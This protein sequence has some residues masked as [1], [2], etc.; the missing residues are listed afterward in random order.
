MAPDRP[1]CTFVVA[2]GTADRMRG[3]S[4]ATEAGGRKMRRR[5]AP[6][7]A[8]TAAGDE[9]DVYDRRRATV[10]GVLP[11]ESSV[12]KRGVDAVLSDV[13]DHRFQDAVFQ[14][15]LYL[16]ALAIDAGL[17]AAH[18]TWR[19][20]ALPASA[21]QAVRLLAGFVDPAV[22]TICLIAPFALAVVHA[23]DAIGTLR[24]QCRR[25][26]PNTPPPC[27]AVRAIDGL[28]FLLLL[29]ALV[30]VARHLDA[31]LLS[32]GEASQAATRVP[33]ALHISPTLITSVQY[34]GGDMAHAA[35]A[36]YMRCGIGH[37]LPLAGGWYRRSRRFMHRD[38]RIARAAARR[39][40][41]LG[42]PPLRAACA[43]ADGIARAVCLAAHRSMHRSRGV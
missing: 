13:K 7:S 8:T 26:A 15:K 24:Q 25:R 31:T 18:V 2:G 21:N 43:G 5:V 16:L 23:L 6:E 20:L 35:R 19:A 11:E 4:D 39:S 34:R 14:S 40:S 32:V 3:V 42:A 41:V 30:D 17:G 22:T 1:T 33:C 10:A 28:F 9:D 37:I 36:L 29:A 12:G 27:D 38:C